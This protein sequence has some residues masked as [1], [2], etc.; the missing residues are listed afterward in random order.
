VTAFPPVFAPLVASFTPLL[1]PMVAVFAPLVA[2]FH[3]CGLSLGLGCPDHRCGH[4][5][6]R[7]ET[8]AQ[9]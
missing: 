7:R 9:Y 4:C 5:D 8:K 6:A 1:T 3:A 2:A